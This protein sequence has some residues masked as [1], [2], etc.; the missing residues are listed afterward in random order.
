MGLGKTLQCIALMYTLL[1][2]SPHSGKPTIDKCIIVCPSS[3]V[4]NWANELSMSPFFCEVS[5]MSLTPFL[6]SQMARD[7]GSRYSDRRWEGR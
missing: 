5:L 2:Q 4:R 1:K 6:H 7:R 3:L